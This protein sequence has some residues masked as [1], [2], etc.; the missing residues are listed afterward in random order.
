MSH[1]DGA[2][3]RKTFKH[4]T[5]RYFQ[6]LFISFALVAENIFCFYASLR[7]I[8]K[9]SSPLYLYVISIFSYFWNFSITLPVI[10]SINISANINDLVSSECAD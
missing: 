4:H 9:S 8:M 5:I 7:V 3:E 1:V 2:V 10:L 6:I